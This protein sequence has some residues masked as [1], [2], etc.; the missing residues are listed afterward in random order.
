MKEIEGNLKEIEEIERIVEI[1]LHFHLQSF[2][3]YASLP[4]APPLSRALPWF[5]RIL[6]SIPPTRQC[7]STW[8][9]HLVNLSN[10]SPYGPISHPICHRGHSVFRS[11]AKSCPPQIS[12]FSTRFEQDP[13]ARPAATRRLCLVLPCTTTIGALRLVTHPHNIA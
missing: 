10:S 8:R 7:N 9:S 2:I 5:H 12:I 4:S 11:P 13:T 6:A 1:R 3:T